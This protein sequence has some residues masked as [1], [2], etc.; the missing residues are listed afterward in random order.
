MLE[1]LSQSERPFLVSLQYWDPHG[2]HLIPDEFWRH[3]D[4]EKLTVWDNFRDDLSGKAA[5]VRRERDDFYR[6]HPRTE[7]EVIE[8]LGLYCDHVALLD[9]Q[10]GRL[11]EYVTSRGLIEDT[12]IVFTSDHGDMTGAHGG[13]VDKGLPYEEAM[14]VPLVFSHQLSRLQPEEPGP[15]HGCPSYGH[16][17]AGN[18]FRPLSGS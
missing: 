6:L 16:G 10:I 5:R 15:E 7:D 9:S 1:S 11:M 2:P 17:S 13:L 8:Y 18:T 4:R 3:T 12:L 14:R